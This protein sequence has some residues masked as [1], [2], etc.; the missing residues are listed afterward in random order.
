MRKCF[1]LL[2]QLL[3]LYVSSVLPVG[4]AVPIPGTSKSASLTP[5]DTGQDAWAEALSGIGPLILLI[6]EKNTKQ[7]LREANGLPAILSMSLAPMG[8]LSVLTNMIRL[9]GSRSLRSYLG[10]EHE[11]R[12]NAALEMTKANC[13]GIHGEVVD[14]VVS[15]STTSDASS[16][17]LAVIF[18][19]GNSKATIEESL[20]QIQSCYK[21][22]AEKS[23]RGC[24]K[25]AGNVNWCF[26]ITCPRPHGKGIEAISGIVAAAL[27][28]DHRQDL[29]DVFYIS[30]RPATDTEPRASF[31]DGKPETRTANINGAAQKSATSGLEHR[32]AAPRLPAKTNPRDLPWDIWATDEQLPYPITSRFFCTFDGLSEIN[33]STPTPPRVSLT[34]AAISFLCMLGTQVIALWQDGWFSTGIIMVFIGYFCM[35]IGVSG[36]GYMIYSACNSALIPL[37]PRTTS[38]NWASGI[39]VLVKNTDSLDTT[40]SRLLQ[41][42]KRGQVFQ[43][44]WLKKQGRLRFVLT[45]LIAVFLTLAFITYYLGLRSTQWWL[46]ISQ[47]GVCLIAAFARSISKMDLGSFDVVDDIRLDKRCYSTGILEMQRASRITQQQRTS[48]NLDLRIYSVQSTGCLPLTGELIAWRVAKLCLEPKYRV[49]GDRILSATGMKLALI[50]D[51]DGSLRHI[52]VVFDGGVVALEG[53]AFPNATMAVAFSAVLTD[54]AAPTPLLAR[55]IMRQPQ[56]SLE[57]TQ[58][59]GKDLPSMGGT[60]ISTFDSLMTWWT[61]AE[62][63]NELGDQHKNLHGSF[64]LISTAYFLQLLRKG[65]QTGELLNAIDAAHIKGATEEDN[66]CAQDF[67]DFLSRSLC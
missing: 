18:L 43:A 8:L 41:A 46:S 5:T 30:H 33:T 49:T 26:R 64:V 22:Q 51:S 12:T 29:R 47:L 9:C 42:E 38:A 17:A 7:L 50:G 65:E 40:G 52:I 3:Q 61:L 62:D 10:Y 63:R 53:L 37:R 11:P 1:G 55:G 24:P 4:G 35:I 21:F 6:G 36:A 59:N 57:K 23:A 14:G 32:I 45:W 15:R 28:V 16:Q 67:V 66:N 60:Y 2:E 13:G 34:V 56:W 27:N 19:R 25:G 44:V 31:S 39:V 20:M 58:I 54:L 48:E